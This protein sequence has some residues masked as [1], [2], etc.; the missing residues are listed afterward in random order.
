MSRYSSK[1][2]D[3]NPH[4]SQVETEIDYIE[5]QVNYLKWITKEKY[6]NLKTR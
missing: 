1:K 5:P 2:S 4:W 6:Q 3:D